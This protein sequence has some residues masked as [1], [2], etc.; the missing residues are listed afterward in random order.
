MKPKNL[1]RLLLIFILMPV[2]M[3]KAQNI[4][5]FYYK[6]QKKVNCSNGAVVSA[7]AL[8]SKVGVTILLKGGNAIDA[9]IAT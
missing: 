6:Q 8:A 1:V 9:A 7:N 2:S 5:P 3:A 4:D